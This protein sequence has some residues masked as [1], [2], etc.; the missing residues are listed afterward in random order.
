MTSTAIASILFSNGKLTNSTT[1]DVATKTELERQHQLQQ[2]QATWNEAAAA[3]TWKN[4]FIPPQ[5]QHVYNGF[6]PGNSWQQ[7]RPK[8]FH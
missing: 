3:M 2:Q 4:Q 8:T 6:L 5:Q 1:V 7:V